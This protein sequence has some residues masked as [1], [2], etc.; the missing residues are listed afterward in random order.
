[1]TSSAAGPVEWLFEAFSWA[2]EEV[3]V[4]CD[5]ACGRLKAI[6]RAELPSTFCGG[7]FLEVTAELTRWEGD[8]RYI[9]LEARR[10][11]GVATGCEGDGGA[12][13]GRI[14]HEPP[15]VASAE[16]IW[17]A[18]DVES[19]GQGMPEP[20]IVTVAPVGF[21][22]SREATPYLPLSPDEIAADVARCVVEGAS[23]VHLHARDPQGDRT[24]DPARYTDIVERIKARCDVV[25]Q[26]TTEGDA[27]ADVMTR[28]GPLGAE[29]AEMASLATGTVNRGDHI[30][31]NSKPVIE[32]I[33]SNIKK[34]GL[35]ACVEAWDIGFLENALALARKG[36]IRLPG[37]FVL[38]CGSKGGMGAR[39]ATLEH[40]VSLIPR[41]STWSVSGIGRHQLPMAERAIAVG[42][43]V[44]V[45]LEDTVRLSRG[46]LSQGN[47]PLVAKVVEMAK[48]RGRAVADASAARRV[49]GL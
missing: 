20:L 44:R 11:L 22:V 48:E 41:G 9:E 46:E 18:P 7:D 37:H 13:P 27:S 19:K 17:E 47:A 1:M 23:V 4:R 42:G 15:V 14:M 43:H 3:L 26:V 38:M 28:C 29:G 39:R 6:Q 8:L 31:F 36:L 49:L 32:H 21:D 5:G 33:A 10:V 40:A 25:I 16:A 35:V 12:R 45:G 34:A 24:H 2:S 30:C